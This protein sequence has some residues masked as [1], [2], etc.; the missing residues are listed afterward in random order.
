MVGNL[1]TSLAED[2][3][4]WDEEDDEWYNNQK[5][6]EVLNLFTFKFKS[7]STCLAMKEIHFNY[8]EANRGLRGR[9]CQGILT[10]I[11]MMSTR[12]KT[13]VVVE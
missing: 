4:E 6:P 7:F 5:L 10:L 2:E 8:G 13:F 1:P 9:G 12:K 11:N 3:L